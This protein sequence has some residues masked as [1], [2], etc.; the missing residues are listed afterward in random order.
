MK[1]LNSRDEWSGTVERCTGKALTEP[2]N[3]LTPG[4]NHSGPFRIAP[5][6]LQTSDVMPETCV[7]ICEEECRRSHPQ[8]AQPSDGQ[9][10]VTMP[11]LLLTSAISRGFMWSSKSGL[12]PPTPL[13]SPPCMLS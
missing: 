3:P 10:S 12:A 9:L 11:I 13:P 2:L 6:R 5:L 4:V 1:T 8:Q 7:W